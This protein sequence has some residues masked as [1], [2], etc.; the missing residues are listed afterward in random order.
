MA[1]Y[2]TLANIKDRLIAESVN[3]VDD[4]FITRLIESASAIMAG[5]TGV[6]FV[7]AS[8]TRYFD[9]PEGPELVVDDLSP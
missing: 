2:T 3:P 7:A 4:Q 6:N 5:G 9:V 8:G 1:Q